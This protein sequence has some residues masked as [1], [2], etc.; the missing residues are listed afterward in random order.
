MAKTLTTKELAKR[1][2]GK[3]KLQMLTAA[4]LAQPLFQGTN[5]AAEK[6]AAVC[7][8]QSYSTGKTLI[9]QGA[10]NSDLIFILIGSVIIKPNGRPDTI[11]H[12]GTHIGEMTTIDPTVRR[13]ATVTAKVDTIIARVREHDF[14]KIAN[15]HPLLWR[16][17]ARE[18]GQRLRDRVLKVKTK[19][20]KPRIFIGSSSESLKLANK[21]K[22]CF[23]KDPFVAKVWANGIFTPGHSYIEALE[24]EKSLADFA[25]LFL[26]PEDKVISRGIKAD[27]PR[28]NLI[29]ELGL[30]M[31]AMNSK[32]ALMVLPKGV[33]LKLPSDLDGITS[34]RYNP[35]NLA[36][37][38]KELRSLFK[39][40]GTK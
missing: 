39:K 10:A 18:L 31:G 8:I 7:K 5:G 36:S 9:K 20:V 30:F 4:L 14:S 32:R 35:K 12:S 24:T 2:T 27:A 25:V 15:A 37:A 11:R 17:I 38:A 34:I 40:N 22:A 6:M 29:F 33:H 19:N 26:G 16:Q 3:R 1:F 21:L 28:D 13:S 23:A